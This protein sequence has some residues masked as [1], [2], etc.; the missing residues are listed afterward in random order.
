MLHS[1]DLVKDFLQLDAIRD[2]IVEV[3]LELP[4]GRY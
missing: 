3:I 2:D 1:C 4:S